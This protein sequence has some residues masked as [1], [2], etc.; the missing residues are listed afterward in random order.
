MGYLLAVFH[1]IN[2][3]I[4]LVQWRNTLRD[5]SVYSICRRSEQILTF[6]ETRKRDQHTTS[7]CT[8]THQVICFLPLVLILV[9][10]VEE[11][12]CHHNRHPHE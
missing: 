9:G 2:T 11:Y 8:S 4:E 10:E 3:K 6:K 5:F 12:L 7:L 1:Q